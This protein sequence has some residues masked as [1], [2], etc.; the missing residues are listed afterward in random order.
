[1]EQGIHTPCSTCGKPS[2]GRWE[3]GPQS[4]CSVPCATKAGHNV[5]DVKRLPGTYASYP[6][7]AHP[8]TPDTYT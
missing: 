6:R 4:F 2:G 7:K 3:V 8:T 5:L 1:M